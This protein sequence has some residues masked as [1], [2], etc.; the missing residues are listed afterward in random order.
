VAEKTDKPARKAGVIAL[1]GRAINQEGVTVAE[2]NGK[3]LVGY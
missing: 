2:A 1:T 3:M